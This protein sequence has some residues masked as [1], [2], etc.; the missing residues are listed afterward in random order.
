[1]KTI[2]TKEQITLSVDCKIVP[3]IMLINKIYSKLV[4]KSRPFQLFENHIVLK[5]VDKK[6]LLTLE[7]KFQV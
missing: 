2:L 1:M 7:I 4:E 5:K 3:P 6:L